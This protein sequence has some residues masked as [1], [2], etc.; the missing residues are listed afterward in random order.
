M[1]ESNSRSRTG[2][3]RSLFRKQAGCTYLRTIDI[4]GGNE[5]NASTATRHKRLGHVNAVDQEELR[6]KGVGVAYKGKFLDCSSCHA[7]E[8]TRRPRNKEMKT[9]ATKLLDRVFI[10][11]NGP[12]PP[13]QSE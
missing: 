9:L 3:R 6:R 5:A 2:I 7:N 8:K 1:L 10:D 13:S 11:I 12:F 4:G